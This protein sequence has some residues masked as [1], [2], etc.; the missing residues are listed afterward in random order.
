[1][2]PDQ[3]HNNTFT[4]VIR[5]PNKF[6]SWGLRIAGGCDLESPIVVTKVCFTPA[7]TLAKF[8]NGKMPLPQISK[9]NFPK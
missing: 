5:R 4:V 1:M 7:R 6:H 3:A 2:Q 9:L 8:V